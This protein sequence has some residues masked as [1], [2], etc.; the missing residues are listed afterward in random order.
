MELEVKVIFRVGPLEIIDVKCTYT[1]TYVTNAFRGSNR[2]D[3]RFFTGELFLFRVWN[4][5]S[6]DGSYRNIF[7][8]GIRWNLTFHEMPT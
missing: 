6:E 7:V 5:H 8:V 3:V 4:V 2:I 1:Y